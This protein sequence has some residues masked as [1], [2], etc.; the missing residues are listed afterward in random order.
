MN[1]SGVVQPPCVA[2]G[3]VVPVDGAGEVP[4]ASG[5]SGGTHPP[6]TQTQFDT[7]WGEEQTDGGGGVGGGGGGA[8]GAT[9]VT[10]GGAVTPIASG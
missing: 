2:G 1:E 9:G 10:G 7:G 3:V 6:F 8:V 5:W 4:S